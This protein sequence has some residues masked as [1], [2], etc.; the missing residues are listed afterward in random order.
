MLLRLDRHRKGFSG[1]SVCVTGRVHGIFSNNGFPKSLI[2]QASIIDSV[3][4]KQ[5]ATRAPEFSILPTVQD[6]A[7]HPTHAAIEAKQVPIELAINIVR[8]LIEN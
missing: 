2:S 6:A 3:N 7:E 5:Y 4:K 8:A 1:F